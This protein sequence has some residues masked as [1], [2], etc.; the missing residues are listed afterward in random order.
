MAF[1]NGSRLDPSQVNDRR[2]MGRTIAAGGGGLGLIVLIVSLLLG[3][4]PGDLNN[5]VNQAAPQVPVSGGGNINTLQQECKTGADA[6]AS[7]DCRIV[8]LC[9][10]YPGILDG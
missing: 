4:N 6:N 9:Q 1:N 2:G 3:V 8:G 5:I 10:Q 7:E